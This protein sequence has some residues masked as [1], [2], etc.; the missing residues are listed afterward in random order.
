[1]SSTSLGQFLRD[2]RG[3]FTLWS[4]VWFLLYAAIGG[5]AVD[6]TDAF[7]NQSMLQSTADAAALAGAMSLPDQTDVVSQATA[8]ARINMNP[9]TNG[10]VLPD[11]EVHIGTWDFGAETFSPGGSPPNAVEVI[12]QRAAS[13]GNP[14]LTNFLRVIGLRQWDVNAEAIAVRGVSECSNNGLIADDVL[15]Q[16]TSNGYY[17][18]ICI[19]GVKGMRLRQANY[20]EPGTA[21]STTCN[22][23]PGPY[24]LANTIASNPG[25]DD[26]WAAGGE[27]A[28]LFPL[29][30]MRSATTW[31]C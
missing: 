20:F 16:R 25:F 13:N 29:T 6:V 26:A 15:D 12:T 1:M 28:P 21:A 10:V 24:T 2:E 22:D 18:D 23:C 8:Y 30:P 3:S 9:D 27:G 31:T 11:A 4:L 17:N 19:H 5:L 14:V 7:R